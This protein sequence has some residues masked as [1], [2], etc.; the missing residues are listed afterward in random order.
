MSALNSGIN[1]QCFLK[2]S[3]IGLV[4]FYAAD[5]LEIKTNNFQNPLGLVIKAYRWGKKE[6][7]PVNVA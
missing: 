4:L 1:D 3:D 2:S 6:V 7:F 5:L